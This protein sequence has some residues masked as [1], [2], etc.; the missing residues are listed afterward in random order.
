MPSYLGASVRLATSD[1]DKTVTQDNALKNSQLLTENVRKIER[2]FAAESTS[3]LQEVVVPGN[4]GHSLR[5]LGE[6]QDMPF[7]LVRAGKSLFH[8]VGKHPAEKSRPKPVR[9]R[10]LPP[11][12]RLPEPISDELEDSSSALSSTSSQ[13]GGFASQE[14]T[15]P[16]A[17]TESSLGKRTHDRVSPGS[18]SETGENG[19]PAAGCSH[20]SPDAMP[21]TQAQAGL[22]VGLSG[23]SLKQSRSSLGQPSN[24]H[25]APGIEVAARDDSQFAAL[26][27]N[28]T[29]SKNCF[30]QKP[31]SLIDGRPVLDVKIDVFLNGDLCMSTYTQLRKEKDCPKVGLRERFAGRRVGRLFER[32]WILLPPGR[33]SDGSQISI[34]QTENASDECGKRWQA[35]NDQLRSLAKG[36]DKDKFGRK[37]ELAS[38]LSCL[39]DVGMPDDLAQTAC[40]RFGILDVVMTAG[41][42]K[43]E[44][45]DSYYLVNPKL[46]QSSK[47]S[48]CCVQPK[49]TEGSFP[50]GNTKKRS[51]TEMNDHSVPKARPL[52]TPAYAQRSAARRTQTA[53][54]TCATPATPQHSVLMR[55]G[56]QRGST[57]ITPNTGVAGGRQ[58][59]R[60]RFVPQKR[61]KGSEPCHNQ[62]DLEMLANLR[63]FMSNVDIANGTSPA[64][65]YLMMPP[66]PLDPSTSTDMVTC[67]TRSSG[68][69]FMVVP[70]SKPTSSSQE[71]KPVAKVS[72]AETSANMSSP[73]PDLSRHEDT[74]KLADRGSPVRRKAQPPKRKT[75]IHPALPEPGCSTWA[76]S[77]LHQDCVVTYPPTTIRQ[78]GSQRPGHFKESGILFG[79]RYLL[80]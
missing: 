50:T 30:I 33:K 10:L 11:S 27:L 46:M 2:G 58:V 42:G 6:H 78:T 43:K 53:A 19:Q 57:I 71:G 16:H 39:A 22:S 17:Q 64:D 28:I 18:G 76:V 29:L 56:V 9:L 62:G 73:G 20:N 32:P 23:S 51:C 40:R 70:S 66:L 8:S 68:N 37:T 15:I 24:D 14:A 13:D 44:G 52:E 59:G 63:G 1:L 65:S 25:I 47:L 75:P 4:D 49:K 31:S 77:P 36:L 7:F 21:R 35:I 72:F 80:A 45:P 5:F 3:L 67:R 55:S 60:P 12:R 26:S 61:Y 48:L 74:S 79:V 38:Y 41:R 54:H 69:R 34:E